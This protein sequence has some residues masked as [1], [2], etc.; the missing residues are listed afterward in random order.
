M[1]ESVTESRIAELRPLLIVCPGCGSDG[2][3]Y[4]C[5]PD[6]CFNHVCSACLANYELFTQDLEETVASINLSPFEREL[7]QPTVACAR[8]SSLEVYQLDQNEPALIK[9]VCA[10]CRALL[11][12]SFGDA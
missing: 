12:L 3:V 9:L 10:S 4:S 7:S 8:C 11:K 6:C 5:H 2:L 1:K